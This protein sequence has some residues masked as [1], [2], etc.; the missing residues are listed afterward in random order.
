MA[1]KRLKGQLKGV[2]ER[3]KKV[4]P[5]TLKGNERRQ[6]CHTGIKWRWRGV[7]GSWGGVKDR[8]RGIKKRQRVKMLCRGIQGKEEALKGDGKAFNCNKEALN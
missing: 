8:W 7:K 1:T 6:R 3:R 5:K 2:K 4:Y